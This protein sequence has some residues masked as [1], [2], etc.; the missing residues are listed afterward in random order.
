M[1]IFLLPPPLLF[2]SL[3]QTLPLPLPYSLLTKTFTIFFLLLLL[4]FFLLFFFF[5][6]HLDSHNF[7]FLFLFFILYPLSLSLNPYLLFSRVHATL[8]LAL[9]VGRSVRPSVRHI[10]EFRAF[11]ALLLLPNRPWLYCCVSGLVYHITCPPI[12]NLWSYLSG[13][14]LSRARDS[15]TC[16]GRSVHRSVPL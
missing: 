16:V 14:F 6:S 9:S 11:F 1:C 5:F 8:H 10:F 3:T 4:K 2:L 12:R 13:F 15:R 7:L